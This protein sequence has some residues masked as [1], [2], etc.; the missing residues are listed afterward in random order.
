MWLR[1]RPEDPPS[2]EVLRKHAR[3]LVVDDM[4][5]PYQALFE[6]DG[7]H[8]QRWPRIQNL[9]QL[10]DGHFDLI[11]LDLHGVGLEE[12]RER[13]GLGILE[14]V[15]GTNP[16]Q[17]VVAYSAQPW[18]VSNRNSLMLADEVL[19]KSTSYVDFKG[20]VDQL[21][22]RRVSKGYFINKMNR[23]LGDNA[24]LAPKAVSKA[25]RAMQTSR[26]EPL[27]TYLTDRLPD[28]AQVQRAVVIISAGIRIIRAVTAGTP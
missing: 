4:E 21:L 2:L 27:R 18:A 17:V 11:L 25:L 28:M 24:A 7:Y 16:S 23:E 13:Q 22:Q 26:V 1:S 6:R 9:S 19:D 12:S 8:M 15:K 14:H 20:V 3:V 5:F 10:T